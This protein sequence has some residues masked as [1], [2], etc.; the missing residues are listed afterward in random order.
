MTNARVVHRQVLTPDEASDVDYALSFDDKPGGT[1][2]TAGSATAGRSWPRPGPRTWPSLAFFIG[3]IPQFTL[4]VGMF[5]NEQSCPKALKAGCAG[6]GDRRAGAARR[7]PDPL[8]ARGLQGLRWP[9]ASLDLATPS[10]RMSSP[11]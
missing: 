4:A 6:V 9:V 2:P 1:A 3:T 11:S 10:Q 8:R 5:T 7:P